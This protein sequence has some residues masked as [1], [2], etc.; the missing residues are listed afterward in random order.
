MMLFVCVQSLTA[1]NAPA[2][3]VEGR[4]KQVEHRGS[5]R[6][7]PWI[8]DFTPQYDLKQ[9]TGRSLCRTT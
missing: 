8:F 3:D 1:P 9:H 6:R 7:V 2:N 5:E 4:Q